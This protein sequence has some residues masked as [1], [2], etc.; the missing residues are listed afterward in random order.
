[1]DKPIAFSGRVVSDTELQ[2]IRDVVKRYGALTRMEL[3]NTVCELL[4]WQRNAGGLKG[5]ECREFL[6]LLDSQGV[7]QLPQKRATKSVGSRTSIPVSA[8]GV[9]GVALEGKVDAFE[10]IVLELVHS[11][12]QRLLFRE[13]VGRYHYLGYAVPFGAHL[14]YLIYSGAQVL[15]CMQ[16]SS[17]AWR[18]A[19]RDK[20]IGWDELTRKSNLQRVVNQSRFLILPWIHISNLASVVLS[21]GLHQLRED[22]KARYAVAPLLVETLVDESRYTGHCYRAANW[23]RLGGTT[24]RGRMDRAH[25]RE[26]VSPKAIWVYPLATEAALQLRGQA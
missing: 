6:E 14:R 2:L 9:P 22:W 3:A 24:G 26:G 4:Q 11:E 18:M 13:L 8:A 10:P 25:Q 1:M 17:P 15:G 16:F 5:R 7:I 20:W 19:A 23:T 21:R 12:Q